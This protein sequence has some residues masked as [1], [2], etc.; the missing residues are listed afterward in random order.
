MLPALPNSTVILATDQEIA[1]GGP[2]V[3]WTVVAPELECELPIPEFVGTGL[4]A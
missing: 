2:L 1:R 3:Y 4:P